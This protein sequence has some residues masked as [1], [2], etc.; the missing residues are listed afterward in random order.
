M[1]R[2]TGRTVTPALTVS[3]LQKATSSSLLPSGSS[4]LQSH[5]KF[6]QKLVPCHGNRPGSCV[7]DCLTSNTDMPAHF[8]LLIHSI[9]DQG[10]VMI[11]ASPSDLKSAIK[12]Y[13][14]CAGRMLNPIFCS[15]PA[16]YLRFCSRECPNDLNNSG[17]RCCLLP[18]TPFHVCMKVSH[19]HALYV[20]LQVLSALAEVEL[21]AVQC[22]HMMLS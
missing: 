7:T 13:E 14:P 4:G 18:S 21:Q 9:P 3:L 11:R 15:L 22:K 8:Q 19:V 1:T 17:S 12:K 10:I 2:L 16:R 6:S 20:N 5:P